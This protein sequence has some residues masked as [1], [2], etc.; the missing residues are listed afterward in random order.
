[1]SWTDL[2]SL[3]VSP[4]TWCRVVKDPAGF[5]AILGPILQGFLLATLTIGASVF[6]AYSFLNERKNKNQAEFLQWLSNLTERYQSNEKYTKIR[7][8][9]AEKREWVR[10]QLTLELAE[11]KLLNIETDICEDDRAFVKSA[12]DSIESQIDWEFLRLFTDYLYFFEQVLAFG[13]SFSHAFT[14]RMARAIVN[15]FGWFL[16]SLCV[17]WGKGKTPVEELELTA[18]FAFYLACN[19]YRRL[20]EVSICFI[21]GYSSRYPNDKFKEPIRKITQRTFE[22]IRDVFQNE[23]GE[24]D[25]PSSA[26]C[27]IQHWAPLVG[28]IGVVTNPS[29]INCVDSKE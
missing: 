27:L 4:E 15:H 13:D 19:R 9:L 12:I 3:L 8:L 22:K 11:D 28:G 18:L 21:E 7:I 14:T 2:F 29:H 17:S 20:A 24:K 16:R 6:T 23:H 25:F 5:G 1:M 10:R 26:K